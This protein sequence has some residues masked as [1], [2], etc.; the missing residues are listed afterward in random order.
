ML[1]RRK[2]SGL[3]D[4]GGQAVVNVMKV[5]FEKRFHE[6]ELAKYNLGGTFQPGGAARNSVSVNHR[7]LTFERVNMK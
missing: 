1:G 5:R 6:V 7:R 2:Q 4:E 3:R